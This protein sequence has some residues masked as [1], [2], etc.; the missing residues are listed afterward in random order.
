MIK[1]NTHNRG[2]LVRMVIFII[3]ILIVLAYF[4]LNLRSIVASPTFQ[5][6]WSY[7]TGLA[8]DIWNKYLSGILSYLWTHLVLPLLEPKS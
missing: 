4:G 3:I 2:G 1:H 7:V 5:D 6:N 8:V